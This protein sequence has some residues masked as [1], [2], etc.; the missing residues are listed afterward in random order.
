[1]E[2]KVLL[3]GPDTLHPVVIA[4]P[5][6]EDPT[7]RLSTPLPRTLPCSRLEPARFALI[8]FSPSQFRSR[9]CEQPGR[10]AQEEYR[11]ITRSMAR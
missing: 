4:V 1:M 6:G 7:Q 5:E 3:Q 11:A 9:T 8:E 10:T 2:V